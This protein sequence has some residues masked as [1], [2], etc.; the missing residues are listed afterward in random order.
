V[1]ESLDD[2]RAEVEELHASRTRLVLAADVDRRRIERELHDGPQQ[3]LVALAVNLQ[4]ARRLV[5]DDP[6]AAKA[7]IDELRRDVHEALDGARALAHRIYPPLL[8]PAGLAAALRLAATAN[9]AR[10]SVEVTAGTAW[11][12]DLV[13]TVYL[14]CADALES[15]GAGT[16]STI[17]V[18]EDEGGALVFELVADSGETSTPDL[19]RVRD[20]VEALGGRLAVATEPDGAT[21][22]VGSLPLPR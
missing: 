2:L 18:R 4:L 11:P 22:V 10:A 13:G 12:L 16:T 19:V 14:S 15:F 9:G 7:L 1:Q 21:R 5:D 6:D 3:H 8:Q 17:S 20:R